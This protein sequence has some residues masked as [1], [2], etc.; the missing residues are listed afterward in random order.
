MQRITTPDTERVMVGGVAAGQW[1]ASTS[2]GG[3]ADRVRA[4]VADM[5]RH[6]IGFAGLLADSIFSSD[7]VYPD[8][9]GYL[10]PVI[11]AVHELGGV[12][13]AD[14]VQPGFTRTGDAFWGFERQ[15]IVPD[16]VTS[17]K[18][19][20]NGLPTS[21]MAAR[22]EVLE[23]FAGSVPY[24]NTFG[25]NPVCMAASQAVLDVMRDEDT[26]GNAKRVGTAFK[27]AVQGLQTTHAC[28]GDVRGAGL[29]I[30]CE[31]VKPGTDAPDQR[32]ALDLLEA[33]RN[34]HVLTPV[35]GRYGTIPK[36]PPPPVSSEQDVAWFMDAFVITLHDPCVSASSLGWRSD[37]EPC[38][39]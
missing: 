19:M 6:G 16:L 13:I 9:I 5:R 27:S 36:L 7:G 14:E 22:H 35:C 10:E 12:W 4:A 17:G 32:T 29:Y 25:G 11:D 26:M 3:G 39:T 18:P 33:L 1:G 2:G 23:P 28:I 15:G 37:S 24:F 8:P 34:H 30:G 31:I 38:D 20:A 21:L